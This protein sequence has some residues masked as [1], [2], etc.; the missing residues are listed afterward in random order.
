[1]SGLETYPS[2]VSDESFSP[3]TVRITRKISVVSLP[4]LRTFS[5]LQL[6]QLV[7]SNPSIASEVL[8][9]R[10]RS[11][12][13]ASLLSVILSM[14]M[15][16][17]SMEVVNRIATTN[18]D[19]VPRDFIRL[20]ITNCIAYCENQKDKYLQVFKSFYVIVFIS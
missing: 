10:L 16:V 3:A 17:H 15:E 20:Y 19:L 13:A 1:M 5:P 7:E 11:G 14:D 6:A 9:R 4:Y 12:D 8:L 2:L 18:A